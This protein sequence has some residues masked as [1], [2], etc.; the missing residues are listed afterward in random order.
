MNASVLVKEI[1]TDFVYKLMNFW[2]QKCRELNELSDY[3]Q[4]VS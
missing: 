4:S 1:M 2:V 3:Q